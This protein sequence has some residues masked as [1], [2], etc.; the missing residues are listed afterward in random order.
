[1]I[2]QHIVVITHVIHALKEMILRNVLNAS[3]A[4]ICLTLHQM[5]ENVLLKLNVE[6]TIKKVLK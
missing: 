6:P 5:E 2:F 4:F 1:M 3:M